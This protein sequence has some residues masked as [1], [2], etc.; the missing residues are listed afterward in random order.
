ME[1]AMTFFTYPTVFIT[2]FMIFIVFLL[3]GGLLKGLAYLYFVTYMHSPK[4]VTDVEA[5]TSV[6]YEYDK[7]LKKYV[8]NDL[9]IYDK[10][11]PKIYKID[12]TGHMMSF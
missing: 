5:E 9:A 4:L 11:D 7:A 6:Y 10:N 3:I 12:I 1:Y 2:V 8:R